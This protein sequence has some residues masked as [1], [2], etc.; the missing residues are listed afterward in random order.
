MISEHQLSQVHSKRKDRPKTVSLMFV[1]QLTS[2]RNKLVGRSTIRIA[3]ISIVGPTIGVIVASVP[4]IVSA[5]ISDRIAVAI[6][7]IA[8]AVTISGIAVAAAAT[9]S[10]TAPAPS[11]FRRSWKCHCGR[12]DGDHSHSSENKFPESRMHYVSSV[13]RFLR[14]N[15]DRSQSDHGPTFARVSAGGRPFLSP[16]WTLVQRKADGYSCTP[17]TA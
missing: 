6:G 17:L 4:S 7:R 5:R 13:S 10:T 3:G 1:E 15:G 12:G 16:R 2:P 9:P 11:R 14:R 8:V